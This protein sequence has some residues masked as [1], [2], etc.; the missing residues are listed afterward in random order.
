M[1]L[2]RGILVVPEVGSTQI[3]AAE[4]LEKGNWPSVVRAI[5]Q[6][7]GKG[8]FGRTWHSVPEDS[9]T[10]TFIFEPLGGENPPWLLSMLVAIVCA[11]ALDCGLQWPN[12]LVCNG[13]KLG[14]ILSEMVQRNRSWFT[15]VGVGL[16]LGQASF[17]E[18][19]Q[20][21]ATSL[22]LETGR[23]LRPEKVLADIVDRLQAEEVPESW[24]AIEERFRLRDQTPGKPYQLFDGTVSKAL[25]VDDEGFLVT[26]LGRVPAAS[27]LFGPNAFDA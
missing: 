1:K 12:D 4:L 7:A 17:P 22:Y 15:L 5:S 6:T 25:R 27:A 26:E 11:E 16:N 18:E 24:R 8:R 19:I 21:R 10:A 3:L 20:H 14:G 13:R 9:L 2:D 23:L